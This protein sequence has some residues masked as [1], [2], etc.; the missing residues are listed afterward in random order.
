MSANPRMASRYARAGLHDRAPLR[1]GQVAAAAGDLEAGGHPLDVPLERP[2]IGLVEV[3]HV[4]HEGPVGR[5][6]PTE[7]RQVR[8]AAQLDVEPG[9]VGIG[10]EV[11]GHGRAAPR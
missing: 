7:V 1:A 10:A 9:P 8:V 11:G 2:G 5:G 6:E 3:V 4:E